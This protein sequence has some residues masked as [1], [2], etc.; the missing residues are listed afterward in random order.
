MQHR[1]CT[2]Q[3]GTWNMWAILRDSHVA[4]VRVIDRI[5]HVEHFHNLFA[6]ATLHTAQVGP[7]R[8]AYAIRGRV[9][10]GIHSAQPQRILATV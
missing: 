10:P 3:H 5:E 2:E 4:E 6:H 7:Q 1:A 9:L 8:F